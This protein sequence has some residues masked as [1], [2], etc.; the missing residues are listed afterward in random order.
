M[1]ISVQMVRVEYAGYELLVSRMF[2]YHLC[3][4]WVINLKFASGCNEYPAVVPVDRQALYGLCAFNCCYSGAEVF[5]GPNANGTVLTGSQPRFSKVHPANLLRF[6]LRHVILS[7]SR[8]FN[9]RTCNTSPLCECH[10]FKSFIFLP[11]V[12]NFRTYK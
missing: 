5:G 3:G 1:G 12:E 4:L 7:N 9:F 11:F 10:F 6:T 8:P 2:P